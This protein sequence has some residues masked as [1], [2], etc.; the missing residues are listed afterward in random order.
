MTHTTAGCPQP[1]AHSYSDWLQHMTHEEHINQ[2]VDTS[3]DLYSYTLNPLMAKDSI[4]TSL[5]IP[6]SSSI[7]I[8]CSILRKKCI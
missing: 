6:F 4:I 3:I 1:S 8:G 2:I 5:S 7:A